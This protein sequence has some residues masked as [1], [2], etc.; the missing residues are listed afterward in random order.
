MPTAWPVSYLF[1]VCLFSQ[2]LPSSS[3]ESSSSPDPPTLLQ[4]SCTLMAHS[5]SS[6]HTTL[7]HLEP[8]LPKNYIHIVICMPNLQR[9]LFYSKTM[10][11]Y[12]ST[13]TKLLPLMIF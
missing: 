1:V 9:A 13:T 2:A 12:Y 8:L 10:F 7:K 3:L 6:L 5:I 4:Q 11:L